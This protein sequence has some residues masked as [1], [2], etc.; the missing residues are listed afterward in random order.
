MAEVFAITPELRSLLCLDGTGSNI[1]ML[2]CFF[3]VHI[4]QL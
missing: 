2:T 3:T 4:L 1:H